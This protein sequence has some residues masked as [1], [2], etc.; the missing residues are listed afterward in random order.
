MISNDAP[1][2]FICHFVLALVFYAFGCREGMI[3]ANTGG[4]SCPT[5]AV[6][7]C[8]NGTTGIT[9]AVSNLSP[10]PVLVAMPAR[11]ELAA[12]LEFA[13]DAQD[14]TIAWTDISWC[15]HHWQSRYFLLDGGAP[16][17]G[18]TRRGATRFFDVPYS[19]CVLDVA[20]NDAETSCLCP[21]ATN[22]ILNVNVDLSFCQDLSRLGGCKH[23]EEVG[24]SF[25]FVAVTAMP[26]DDSQWRQI[27]ET[28]S[29]ARISGCAN[30]VAPPERAQRLAPVVLEM[31]EK[32]CPLTATYR[33]DGCTNIIIVISNSSPA[34][35][36]L[37]MPA[38]GA[39]PITV[40]CGDAE[41]I[42]R[43]HQEGQTMCLAQTDLVLFDGHH[44]PPPYWLDSTIKYFKIRCPKGFPSDMDIREFRI[45][46]SYLPFDFLQNKDFLLNLEQ[47]FVNC[48]VVARPT[49]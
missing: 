43:F 40:A 34:P 27:N 13:G 48:E 18:E 17:G 26:M 5:F 39:F 7:Y 22:Q 1:R 29:S 21:S 4:E 16:Q 49:Q 31:V 47:Q 6:R 35:I 23:S 28:L 2:P 24:R 46:L 12:T 41:E 30:P 33:M 3:T 38:D 8:E 42:C 44:T 14:S 9:I 32:A 37:K 36:L 25:D 19:D 20:A 11:K 45:S 15:G 10:A